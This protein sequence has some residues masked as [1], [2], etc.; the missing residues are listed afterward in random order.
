MTTLRALVPVCGGLAVSLAAALACVA[1][2]TPLPW[3]IGPLLAVAATRVAGWPVDALPGGRQAAQWII[4]TALGLYFSPLVAQRVSGFVWLLVL[5]ALFAIAVGYLCGYLLSVLGGTDRTTAVFASVPGG[6]AEMAVL[7]ERFGARVDQVAAAQSIRI[8]LVV[9]TIPSV[10]AALGAAVADGGR[11]PAAD[12]TK[13]S[14]RLRFGRA[15][16]HDSADDRGR[17]RFG[18]AA[19]ITQWRTIAAWLRAGLSIQSQLSCASAAFCRRCCC[20]GSRGDGR[21]RPVRTNDGSP[22]RNTSGDADPCDRSWRNRG[23]GRYRSNSRP[24]SADG[25]IVSRH[26]GDT[27]AHVYRAALRVVTTPAPPRPDA[28]RPSGLTDFDL[29]SGLQLLPSVH[30]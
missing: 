24:G 18:D 11:G 21:F 20:D 14:Q 3:M 17:E 25:D 9:V 1:L 23:D 16:D 8:L 10:F 7:G 30:T 13:S 6:A 28:T 29:A 15:L 2:H 12:A 4:G 19:S 22:Y 27:P 26:A 5:G